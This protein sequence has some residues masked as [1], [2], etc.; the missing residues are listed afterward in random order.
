MRRTRRHGRRQGLRSGGEGGRQSPQRVRPAVV[1]REEE[2]PPPAEPAVPRRGQG[3]GHQVRAPREAEVLRHVQPQH[4]L[5]ELRRVPAPEPAR[6]GLQPGVADLH[7]LGG[8]HGALH[9]L[10]GARDADGARLLRR[11]QRL[12]LPRVRLRVVGRLDVRAEPLRRRLLSARH[13]RRLQHGHLRPEAVAVDPVARG[14]RAA[15]PAGL[16][17]AGRAVDSALR[18]PGRG[19]VPELSPAARAQGA[20]P[21]EAAAGGARRAVAALVGEPAAPVL[22]DAVRA[23]RGARH[24]R[25]P[26]LG[27][28]RVPH[29]RGPLLRPGRRHGLRRDPPGP[30]RRYSSTSP[31][32]TGPCARSRATRTRPSSA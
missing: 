30:G 25:R 26:S 6:Q 7:A 2:P 27:R 32:S 14:H 22:Q 24:R 11:R 29:G 13:G 4:A 8:P 21:A 5:R 23:P 3:Q 28:V 16:V 17:R 19:R 18:A 1:G 10:G 31:R 15:L 9:R 20:A 12:A